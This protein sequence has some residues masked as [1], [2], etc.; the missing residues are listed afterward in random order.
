VFHSKVVE[1][2]SMHQTAIF[3]E[4]LSR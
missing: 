1:F 4:Y 2:H 3:D